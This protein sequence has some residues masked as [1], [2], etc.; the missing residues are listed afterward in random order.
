[1]LKEIK[2]GLVFWITAWI[3]I[4]IIGASYAAFTAIPQETDGQPLTAT[5]W[6]TLVD[7]L[8]SIDEKQL[9]TAWVNFDGT[10]CTAWVGNNECIIRDSYN[11]LKVT[12]SSVGHFYI[13]FQTIMD[14]QNYVVTWMTWWSGWTNWDETFPVIRDTVN[15]NTSQVNI[16]VRDRNIS[17]NVIDPSFVDIVIF[18]WK[19]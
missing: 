3:S 9:A 17:D 6:N 4:L 1:M 19:N 7:R 14:H 18:G 10:N 15:T 2:S 5:K 8:N 12:R 16:I 13:H 11:V